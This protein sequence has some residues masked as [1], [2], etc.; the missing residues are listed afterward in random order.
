[1]SRLREKQLAFQ[2]M[3]ASPTTPATKVARGGALAFVIFFAG[4]GLTYVSQIVIARIVGATSYG[5]YTYA[6]AWLT[7]LAYVAA[8]GFDVA[9]LRFVP[10]YRAQRQIGLM[11][12][13]VRFAER[14]VVGAGV[15]LAAVGSGA[16]LVLGQR[17][18]P[19]LRNTFLIGF[20]LVP[21]LALTWIRAAVLRSNDL[22]ALPLVSSLIVRDGLLTLLIIL[23]GVGL[24]WRLDARFVMLAM[25]AGS[26]CGLGLASLAKRRL[27]VFAQTGVAEI[28][29]PKLWAHAALPLLIIGAVDLLMN[30]AGVLCLGWMGETK[31]A[32]IFGLTFNI[33]FLVAI[34][35][36]ALNTLFAPAVSKLHDGKDHDHLQHLI[37]RSTLWAVC[38]A[39][40]V[41]VGIFLLS[42]VLFGWFGP[43]FSAGLPALK[44]LL[45]GQV[46]IA[47]AGSQLTIMTMTGHER[48]AA[49]LIIIGGIIN[50]V[51]TVVLSRWFGM[52]GA[53][54][55]S[56]ASVLIWNGLMAVVIWR[57]LRLLPG[58]LALWP[59]PFTPELRV[60]SEGV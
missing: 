33:A 27:P 26:G 11:L 60:R 18:E 48:S 9:L 53:A 52:A 46:L 19:E 56:V 10:A 20:P 55:A 28:Y 7:L 40:A 38:T 51:A 14:S 57:R 32:G 17:I 49:L 45:I 5:S 25:V 22:V 34:P 6:L 54:M 12:G 29:K 44:I 8:L 35:R 13:V 21:I 2:A 42:D 31:N 37:G 43:D 58:L 4:A 1:M 24:G 41:A 59:R 36:T 30:R 47:G 23:A 39:A 50:L 3:T 15:I 16:V